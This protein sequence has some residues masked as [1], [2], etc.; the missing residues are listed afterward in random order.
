MAEFKEGILTSVE[1]PISESG[2]AF[3]MQNLSKLGGTEA[4][5]QDMVCARVAVKTFEHGLEFQS[6]CL[7]HSFS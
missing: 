4:D 7:Q 6:L 1:S 2:G 5:A 3:E